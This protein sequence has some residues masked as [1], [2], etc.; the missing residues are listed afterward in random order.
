MTSIP[1]YIVAF[2]SVTAALYVLDTARHKTGEYRW[3]WGVAALPF[4]MNAGAYLWNAIYSPPTLRELEIFQ[5]LYYGPGGICL[6][7]TLVW[8]RDISE[9]RRNARRHG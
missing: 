2:F 8:M 5:C 6:Y 3:R 4:L 7:A 1:G 9:R